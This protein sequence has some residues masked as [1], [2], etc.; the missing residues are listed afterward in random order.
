MTSCSN[1]SLAAF[2]LGRFRVMSPTLP[3]LGANKWV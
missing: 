3:R 2:T 1:P